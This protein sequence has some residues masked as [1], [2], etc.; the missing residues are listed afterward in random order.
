MKRIVTFL[1]LVALALSVLTACNTGENNESSAVS[2]GG[3]NNNTTNEYKDV[4]GNY[5]PKH[6]VRDMDGRLF[7]IIVRGSAFGTYQSD[8]FTTESELYGD[9]INDAV[10][11]RNDKIEE[12]YNVKLDVIKSDTIDNDIRLDCTSNLGTYDAI[13]PSLPALAT[14][15]SERYLVDLTTLENFDENAPWYEQ[16]CSKAFSFGDKLYFTT[17]DITILNKVCTPSVLFNKEMAQKYNMPDLYKL[18]ESKEWTFDKMV[19]LAKQVNNIS[20]SDGSYSEDNIYGMVSSWGDAA[21][22]YGAS[23]ETIC[24]KD[25]DDLPYLSIG[26][27]DRSITIAQKVLE[28]FATGDWFIHAQDFQGKTDDIWETSFEVFYNGRALF[29]PSAFSATTKLRSRSNIMFGI[30][31]MPLMDETQD[32]YYSYCGTGQT[33]GIAIPVCAQDPEYSAYMIEACS[34]WAKNYIT[35]A[36]YDVNLRYKDVRDDESEAMLDIIFDNIVYDIGECYNFGEI[37]SI[38]STLAQN[39]STDIVSSL[40]SKKTEAENEI[41]ELKE[42]Y[43]NN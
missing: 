21:S 37:Y 34:A 8:D 13:M 28:E 6:E 2:V 43:M 32:E 33:A 30:L 41:E 42:T 39:K 31:P 20:T 18:V 40:E 29:R 35:T 16:S 5:V 4:D 10:K 12:L 38:F 24:R 26:A 1:L 11:K 22:F 3:T 7:T 25:S 14:F 15:A 17:G 19:E 9:L 23:G 36:Y 27:S